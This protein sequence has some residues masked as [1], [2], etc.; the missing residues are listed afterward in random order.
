VGV[1]V[2]ASG[3]DKMIK[4]N[5]FLGPNHPHVRNTGLAL[6]HMPSIL[7]PPCISDCTWRQ[8]MSHC[9]LRS[10]SAPQPAAITL[11]NLAEITFTDGGYSRLARHIQRLA[12]PSRGS[13]DFTF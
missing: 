7:A 2:P 8:T 4:P 6:G 13:S 9:W 5:G 3:H 10:R 12:R 11:A 1:V